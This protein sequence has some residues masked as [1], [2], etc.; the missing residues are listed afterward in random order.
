MIQYKQKTLPNSLR[1]IVN[2]DKMTELVAVNMLYKV[3]SKNENPNHTGFA[4]LFE[5]LMFSGSEHFPEFDN[6]INDLGGESNAFTNCD[7]T[8]FYISVPSMYLETILKVEADRMRHLLIDQTHLDVQKKVVI[9]E[10]KQRYLNQPYGDLYK[11]L[12]GLAYKVHPYSW[13]TIGKD[14]SHIENAD[15]HL[16]RSFYSAFYQP[17]N[18]ILSV[19]GNVSAEQV[20]DLAEKIFCFENQTNYISTYPK[21]PPQQE[22][23]F[24]QVSRD[25][26]AS[27]VA[28]SFPICNR[29]DEKFYIFDLI[30]DILSNGK[31]SRLYREF[32][33]EKK[34]FTGIDAV[35]SGDDD[36][37]LFI[38]LAKLSDNITAQKAEEEIFSSIQQLIDNPPTEYE[39]Q[40][41]KNKYI[42]NVAFGNIK[43]LDKA[44]TL[45]YYDHLDILD[46]VN[47]DIHRYEA[48]GVEEMID[49]AKKTFF[50][51]K[52]N[53]LYYLSN[54]QTIK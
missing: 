6:L 52:H 16:V 54:S 17:S 25:V 45:A 38:I 13:Q 5:H 7:I 39:F 1:V 35:V 18:A 31:S 32:V 40:K 51:G 48:I 29:K 41:V 34:I 19:S 44:M 43:I 27:I 50:E 3:G 22:N 53:T 12:R 28:L 30:S 11:L 10:F 20:F 21:E 15:L 36:E 4:H 42:A 33:M 49:L 8:N 2:Q 46:R 14:I 26:P 9:E 47:T 24:L 37:G 23:R